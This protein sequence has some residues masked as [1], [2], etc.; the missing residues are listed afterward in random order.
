MVLKISGTGSEE[1]KV[2]E[3]LNKCL[4]HLE[5]IDGIRDFLEQG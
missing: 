4:P 5:K 3:F 2:G 1:Q